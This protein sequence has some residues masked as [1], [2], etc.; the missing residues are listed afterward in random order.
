MGLECHEH[1]RVSKQQ[2]GFHYINMNCP[3]NAS[4]DYLLFN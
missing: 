4:I 2:A 1:V 3:F